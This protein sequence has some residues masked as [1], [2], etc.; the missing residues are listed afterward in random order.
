MPKDTIYLI[1]PGF[2]DAKKP[3]KRYFCPHCNQIEGILASNPGLKDKVEIVRVPFARPRRPVI[4]R[5]GE[6][7][8]GLPVLV[9]A[10]KSPAPAAA[11]SH[12]A[13]RFVPETRDIIAF[14]VDRFDVPHPHD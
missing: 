10:D 9:L 7:N 1:E 5:I 4:E 6:E 3:G 11:Q 12:G 8:Q 14:L 13:T 2:E